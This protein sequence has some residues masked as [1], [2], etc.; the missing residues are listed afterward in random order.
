M[1]FRSNAVQYKTGTHSLGGSGNFIYD[2]ATTTLGVGLNVVI[3]NNNQVAIG[4]NNTTANSTSLFVVGNGISAGD[5]YDAFKIENYGSK[6]SQVVH[7]GG[8]VNKIN[9]VTDTIHILEKDEY[10]IHAF[11]RDVVTQIYLPPNG[12]VKVGTTYVIKIGPESV[13]RDPIQL[14][15]RTNQYFDGTAGES[16]T[17]ASANQVWRIIKY[18]EIVAGPIVYEY[19]ESW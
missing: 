19:W 8:I 1:L 2:P 10:Y 13:P 3:G 5:R 4:K 6:V 11:S 16:L 15:W 17:T 9:T 18:K 7:G 12:T 14:W